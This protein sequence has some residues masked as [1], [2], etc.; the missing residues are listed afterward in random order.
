MNAPYL[1]SSVSDVCITFVVGQAYNLCFL[2]RKPTSKVIA[3]LSR[4]YAPYRTHDGSTQYGD[5]YGS[6]LS[7][8]LAV[9]RV[10]ELS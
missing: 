7:A 5:T 10:S 6:M 9:P 3:S 1:L 8:Y 4:S 2:S